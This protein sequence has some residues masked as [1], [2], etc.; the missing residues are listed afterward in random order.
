MSLTRCPEGPG[1]GGL[2]CSLKGAGKVSLGRGCPVSRNAEPLREKPLVAKPSPLSTSQPITE[3]R[4]LFW[5][6]GLTSV[7]HIERC[8]EFIASKG[9]DA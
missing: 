2:C 7:G 5:T 4:H 1:E 6:E 3:R 9:D 8:A